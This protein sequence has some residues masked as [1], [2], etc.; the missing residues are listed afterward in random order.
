[1]MNIVAHTHTHTHTRT[2]ARTRTHTHTKECHKYFQTLFTQ[3]AW[4]KKMENDQI[5]EAEVKNLYVKYKY[6]LNLWCVHLWNSFT[7]SNCS[8]FVCGLEH[9]FVSTQMQ[10]WPR[11]TKMSY[12]KLDST[13][14]KKQRQDNN[15]VLTSVWMG[16]CVC[17]Y[18]GE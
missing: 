2:H 16:F 6:L 17:A 9:A 15:A 13:S 18:L 3:E 5:C 4:R 8:V 10:I 12:G 14:I 11:Q 1:M 7:C